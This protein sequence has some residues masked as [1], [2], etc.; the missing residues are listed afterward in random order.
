MVIGMPDSKEE[1][2]G[3]CLRCTEGKLTR[4]P[5]PSCNSKT[6]DVEQPEGFEIHDRESHVCRLKKALSSLKQAPPAWYERIDSYLMKLRFTRSEVDPN[7][8]F[9]VVD[10]K[11][12]ILV[13]YEDDLFLTGTE[14]KPS[15]LQT[16]EGVG[17]RI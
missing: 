8:G 7:H 13:P 4:E 3:T 1:H 11:P 9:K 16:Y 17:F 6:T 5:F 15:Y 2:E 14:S 12:L 10:D